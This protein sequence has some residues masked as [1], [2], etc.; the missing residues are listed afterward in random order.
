ML[1]VL[2]KYMQKWNISI[3]KPL[4]FSTILKITFQREEKRRICIAHTACNCS[5]IFYTETSLIRQREKNIMNLS[6]RE[7]VISYRLVS[8]P[9]HIHPLPHPIH[10][11]WVGV[12]CKALMIQCGFAER[13]VSVYWCL[14]QSQNHIMN[15]RSSA[16]T[17]FTILAPV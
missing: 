17:W 1:Y 12:M 5:L 4:S 8:A 6:E 3:H 7:F 13:C 14:F 2:V 10:T 15:S 11:C 9:A 16:A